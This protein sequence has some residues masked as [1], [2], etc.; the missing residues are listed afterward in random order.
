VVG[1]FHGKDDA[2]KLGLTKVTGETRPWRVARQST[3]QN[4]FLKDVVAGPQ[5]VGDPRRRY[6]KKSPLRVGLFCGRCAGFGSGTCR[7]TGN[8]HRYDNLRLAN[9]MQSPRKPTKFKYAG[10]RGAKL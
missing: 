2:V 10:F 9:Y 5:D 1:F 8:S 4:L 6:H 3:L 7:S